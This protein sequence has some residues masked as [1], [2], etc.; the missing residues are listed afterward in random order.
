[1]TPFDKLTSDIHIHLDRQENTGWYSINCPVCGETKTRTGGFLFGDDSITYNCFRGKCDASCNLTV[2]EYVSRKFKALMQCMGIKTPVE[3]LVAKKRSALQELLDDDSHLYK[4]HSYKNIQ[5]PPEFVPLS[6]CKKR[7]MRDAAIDFFESRCANTDD[8]YIAEEG[9]YKGLSAFGMFFHD[10][11]IGA[12]I[13]TGNGYVSHFDGNS[14][15]LYI[16]ERKIQTPVIVVEGGMDA[17][18]FPNTVATLSNKITPEQAYFLRGRDVIMLP[19]RKGGNRYVEQFS[20]YG[21]SFCVPPWEEKDLNA[22]VIRY[23]I[24]T[25]ARMIKE[26]TT[27]NLLEASARYKLWTLDDRRANEQRGFR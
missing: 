16:P 12:N 27:K 9:R 4:K 13:V 10:K 1:M 25:V 22:A 17:K 8:V 3:L 24:L 19:D 7:F 26:N 23:G 6:E 15:V 20:H 21:W 5:L 18:C 14:H 11:M 2:G